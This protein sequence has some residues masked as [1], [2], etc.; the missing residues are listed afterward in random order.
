[1]KICI[2]AG[3][4]GK[5][6]RAPGVPEYYES[7][8]MWRLQEKLKLALETYGIEAYTT[9]AEQTKDL[10]LYDRGTASKGCDLFISLHSNAAGSSVN[11][12]VDYVRIYHLTEDAATKVDEV[13]KAVAEKLAPVIAETM[14]TKQKYQTQSWLSA[15]DRNKDG[16]LND[17]YLGVLHGARQVGV[18]GILAEHSFHTNDEICRWLLKDE[19]L[20]LLAQAE[21]KSIAQYFGV[22]KASSVTTFSVSMRNLRQGS[23]GED[24]RALQL[25][26][27]GR[28]YNGT[29]NAMD[30]IFGPRTEAAVKAYQ[31]AAGLSVDGIAGTKTMHKLLGL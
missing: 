6:N 28:G 9:R 7:E 10:A 18:P 14:G 1:M 3:H 31:Q 30:G 5:Y 25:L 27:K 2:D 4:Y 19:N 17:N 12:S 8:V 22:K 23:E 16:V 29:M 24:V 13:S 26:L 21:A 20:E 15:S 11:N